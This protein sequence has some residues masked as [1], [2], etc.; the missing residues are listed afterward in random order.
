MKVGVYPGS[1]D[2]ITFGHLD[3]IKRAE[4]LF[5]EII[6]LVADSG[7][8]KHLFSLKERKEML[9]EVF[10]NKKNIKVE[11]LHG[12]LAE[13]MKEKELVF[14]VRGLRAISDFEFEFQHS[15]INKELN[16]EMETVF[17]MTEPKYFYLNSSIIKE[18]VG[19]K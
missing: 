2:P 14:V 15:T 7:K 11:I 13:Y 19:L 4:K 17:F 3:I 16:K 8:K 5:D 6:V 18:I 10:K 9:E 12:L 1:F